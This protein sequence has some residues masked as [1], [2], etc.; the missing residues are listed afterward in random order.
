MA[1]N[2]LPIL[3]EMGGGEFVCISVSPTQTKKISTHSVPLNLYFLNQHQIHSFQSLS[4]DQYFTWNT[5]SFIKQS[6]LLD[7]GPR[8]SVSQVVP[9]FLSQT[10]FSSHFTVALPCKTSSFFIPVIIFHFQVL[11]SKY[12]SPP[13]AS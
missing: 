2:R 6:R 5:S 4:S 12:L 8:D 13:Q 7:S 1:F 10:V 11:V 9:L 3:W